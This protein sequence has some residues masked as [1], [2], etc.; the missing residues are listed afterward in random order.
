MWMLAFIGLGIVGIILLGVV[1]E[2]IIEV[3]RNWKKVP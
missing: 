3:I 2:V 1:V